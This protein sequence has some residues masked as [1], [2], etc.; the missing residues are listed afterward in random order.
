MTLVKYCGMTREADV[1]RACEI[2]VDALGFVLWPGSPRAVSAARAASLARL[3][4]SQALPVAVFVS[5][6]P[7]DVSR[8]A[9]A[10]L[11]VAQ[12]HGDARPEALAAA[13][14]AGMDVWL[15][16]S[17]QTL[18]A[19][20]TERT[21]VLDAHDPVRHGGTGR[22]IDWQAAAAVARGRRVV[23]AGGLTAQNVAD[24]IRV[25]RPHGVDVASGI[26]DGPGT[27]NHEAMAAFMASV[28][29]ADR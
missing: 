13:A 7:G 29:E 21:V 16:C 12:I 26:E 25:V 14:D 20:P 23:L 10:G 3:L 2:G 18:G 1:E 4:P 5:P 15:A 28:R 24:A 17:L 22:T 6:E 27:K 8:A 11:R 19:T 9:D